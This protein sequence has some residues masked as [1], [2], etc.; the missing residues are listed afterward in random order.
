MALSVLT[1]LVCAAGG[2]GHR[3]DPDLASEIVS[4][5]AVS[6]RA[7]VASSS[8]DANRI[9]LGILAAGGNAVDAAVAVA[10]ALGAVDP[11][12]SGLGGGTTI[13][14]RMADG[15]AVAIDGSA[16]VPVAV[17]WGELQRIQDEGQKFGPALAAV[18]GT[19][20]ALDHAL[21]RFGTI[22]LA[23]AVVPSI[24]LAEAGYPLTPFQRAAT[25]KYVDDIR[26][27][28][29]LNRI[30]LTAAGD[31]KAVGE[32]VRWPGLDRT[33][34]RLAAGGA[35][36]FYR[37]S[38][39]A[40]IEADMIRRGG[41]VRRGDLALYRVRELEPLRGSY[42]GHEVLS[43]PLPGAGGAVL[44]GLNILECFEPAVLRRDDAV[45]LQV[46]AEAFHIA[47][48]DQR[49]TVDRANLPQALHDLR[50]LSR[51]HA[52]ARAA[53][54]VPGRPVSEAALGPAAWRPELESQ[55][56]EVSVVDA[57]GNAVALT[58]SLGRFYGNKVVADGLGFPYNTFLAGLDAHR[59]EA[60]PQRAP[61]VVDGAPTIVL[62]DGAPLL[63]LG[64]AGS[65][66][67]PGAIDTVISNVVDRGMA[68]GAAV[69]APRALWSKGDSSPGLLL[70]VWPPVRRCHVRGLQ[71][72]GYE[73]GRCSTLPVPYQDLSS[74]GAVNAVYRDPSTGLLSG[75]GDPRR[76]G[77]AR[78]PESP[79]DGG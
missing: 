45:R 74:F 50:F 39:A 75:V 68:L 37:G 38:I 9:G 79:P 60:V 5:V 31:L 48:E 4:R 20:A 6:H 62:E 66:R 32:V 7:M 51:D 21:A 27:T 40:E 28:P 35:A 2:A 13:L 52:A 65:S 16:V 78:G 3:D 8:A 26:A 67:I 43:F 54:I 57:A 17:D 72:M 63:V 55:T 49:R 14:V 1:V 36:E 73:P 56:V 61:I 69:E 18:P 41:P 24:A 29:P 47:M 77:D 42:R 76:N 10:V 11:G 44:A 22:S 19:V 30:L 59:P 23:E 34:R 12:D 64:A 33:L 25:A 15:R 46:M 71:R 53:L 58:Q 70:E